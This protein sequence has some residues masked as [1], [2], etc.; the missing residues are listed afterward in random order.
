M[1]SRY[2]AYV[3]HEIDYILDTCVKRDNDPKPT[4]EWSEQSTWLG[5]KIVSVDKGG[6]GD[7][8]GTVEFEASY[9]RG[10]VKEL[11]HETAR[12]KKEAGRWL[13]RDGKMA[14]STFVRPSPKIGRNESCPCGSGKKYKHCCGR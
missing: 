11:H 6:E 9:E 12:F 1:R 2:S 4:R 5:L 14:S 3:K 13:Y 10:G 7:D 8:E